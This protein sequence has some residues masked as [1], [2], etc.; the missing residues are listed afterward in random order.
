MAKSAHVSV[1]ARTYARLHAEAK[2]RGVTMA[3]LVAEAIRV[4]LNEFTASEWAKWT[5]ETPQ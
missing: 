4:P 2:R 5:G 1:S 3:S